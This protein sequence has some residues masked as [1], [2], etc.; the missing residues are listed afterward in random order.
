MRK[1]IKLLA[2]MFAF[3][4]QSMT[5]WSATTSMYPVSLYHRPTGWT[6]DNPK[7]SKAPAHY[8]I[9][10]S[11]ILD[12]DNQQLLVTAFADIEFTYYIY[13]EDDEIIFQGVMYANSKDINSIE[14]GLCAYGRRK[15]IVVYN[16]RVFEGTFYV[17]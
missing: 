15:L 16:G 9:P 4:M 13:N 2:I 10:L 14:L 3:A 11:F 5:M 6:G 12:E 8:S 7:P 1:N 17:N